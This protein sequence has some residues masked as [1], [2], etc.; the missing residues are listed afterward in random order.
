MNQPITPSDVEQKLV[1]LSKQ[2]EDTQTQLDEAETEYLTARTDY[3]L[4][5]AKARLMIR[6][7]TKTTVQDCEDRATLICEEQVRNLAIAEAKVKASR[8]KAFMLKTQVDIARSVGTSVRSALE[9]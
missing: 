2:I 8:G 9:L 3:E 6:R 7:T 4:A 1:W 5:I